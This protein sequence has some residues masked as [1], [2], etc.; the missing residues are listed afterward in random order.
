M[1]ENPESKLDENKVQ[2]IA[3]GVFKQ[4]CCCAKSRFI[5]LLSVL[6]ILIYVVALQPLCG[7]WRFAVYVRMD[8]LSWEEVASYG[9]SMVGLLVLGGFL[10]QAWR[11]LHRD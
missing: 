7:L 3:R 1:S 10:L 11:E 2:E 8:P 5:G 4:E 6:I 9:I